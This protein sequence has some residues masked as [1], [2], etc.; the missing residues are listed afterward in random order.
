M[1]LLLQ[2]V[3]RAAVRVRGKTVAEIEAG[4]LI[5]VGVGRAERQEDVEWLAQKV[6][7]LR[8]FEDGGG[9]MN[10][11]LDEVDGQ[12]LVVPQSTLYGDT[13]RGRRPSWIHAAPP[14]EAREWVERF[15]LAL[16]AER[17]QVRRGAFQEHMEVELVNDGPVTLEFERGGGGSGAAG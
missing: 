7:H 15:A 10:R 3:S 11:S 9:R 12:A 14:V 13:S 2:R 6:A 5:L 8:V 1:R 4:Y 16:E 17:V